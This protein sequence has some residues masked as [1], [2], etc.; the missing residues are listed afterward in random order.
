MGNS[1]GMKARKSRPPYFSF[2][3]LSQGMQ[4]YD[5]VTLTSIHLEL[6]AKS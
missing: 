6:H 2:G 4:S 3:P 1:E 5:Y